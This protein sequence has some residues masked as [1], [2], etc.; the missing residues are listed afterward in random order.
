MP[1]FAANLTMLFTEYP[2]LERFER[3][4]RAGFAAVEY[5]FPYEEDTD[6]I[7]RALR[8]YG[9]SQVLFNLPAGNWAAGD[10]GIA[11]D[12]ARRAEFRS[13]VAQA[14]ELAP[15]FECRRINCLAG[16]RLAGVP[17]EEQWACLVDNVRY[18]AGALGARNITLLVEPINTYD[19]PGFFLSTSAQAVRLCE[20]AAVANV[21]VQYDVYHM[22]R[23]EGDLVHT[24]RRLGKRIG[25]VQVADAPDR[26]EPGTG[27]INFPF[28]L[29]T[30]DGMDYDGYVGLEYRPSGRTEESF[31]WIEAM[32]FARR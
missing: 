16:K 32:G 15:R 17:E 21:Q 2:F 18:A 1:R 28:V 7:V 26:R 27:E 30:L 4:A 6:G 23:M 19:I 12:P 25:H 22:Q 29:R 31:G 3:A 13:G 5:M 9:L 14:L 10:R 20:D 8:K 11:V 24:L